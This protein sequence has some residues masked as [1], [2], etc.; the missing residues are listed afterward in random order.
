VI[1]IATAA[2]IAAVA[3]HATTPP[4]KIPCPAAS[5]VGSK[6]GV[7]VKAPTSTVYGTGFKTCSYAVTKG[8]IPI[9]IE[10]QT[11]TTTSFATSENAAKNLGV[12]P[13]GK[14]GQAAWTLKVGGDLYVFNKGVTLKIIAPLITAKKLEALA[15]ALPLTTA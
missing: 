9:R 10:F 14:L 1:R 6:L 12:V 4:S 3:G 15:K 5:L 13:V 7:S 8:K 11:D 2:A